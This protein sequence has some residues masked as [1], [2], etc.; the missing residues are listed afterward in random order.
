MA[1]EFREQSVISEPTLFTSWVPTCWCPLK[2]SCTIDYTRGLRSIRKFTI[3]DAVARRC[4][5][6]KKY[7]IEDNYDIGTCDCNFARVFSINHSQSMKFKVC[8]QLFVRFF[9]FWWMWRGES[10][11]NVQV[12]N[13]TLRTFVINLL[14]HISQKKK[15]PT[16]NRSKTWIQLKWFVELNL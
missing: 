13:L 16:R 7:L 15:N 2:C 12:R 1:L 9:S 14:V 5:N 4:S 3:Y 8:L 11:T 6:T 10:V